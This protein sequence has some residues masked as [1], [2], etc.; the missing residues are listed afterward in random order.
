VTI[1][2]SGGNPIPGAVEVTTG[3]VSINNDLGSGGSP[4]ALT[5]DTGANVT[6]T[7]AQNLSNLTLQPN[8]SVDMAVFTTGLSYV[9]GPVAATDT[10]VLETAVVSSDSAGTI[11]A[12]VADFA[13]DGDGNVAATNVAAPAGAQI[14]G[15]NPVGDFINQIGAGLNQIGQWIGNVAAGTKF[16]LNPNGGFTIQLPGNVP[17]INII[18]LQPGPTGTGGN[19]GN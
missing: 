15:N 8:S 18:P 3:S 10:P 14:Q 12:A 6:F 1:D 5:V 16:T 11:T 17:P 4:V 13:V 7:T 2:E 19:N 9:E